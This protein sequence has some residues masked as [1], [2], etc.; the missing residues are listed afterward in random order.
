MPMYRAGDKVRILRGHGKG[1]VKEILSVRMYA[2]DAGYYLPDERYGPGLHLAWNVELVALRTG[3]NPCR[4][5]C[6]THAHETTRADGYDGHC[7]H[8]RGRCHVVWLHGGDGCD[9][10]NSES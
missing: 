5:D 1:T 2:S 7:D 10:Q 9:P 3:G 6:D 4:A 8:C